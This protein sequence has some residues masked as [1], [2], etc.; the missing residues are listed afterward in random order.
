MVPYYRNY[1]I[2]P[3]GERLVMVC[4][5]DRPDDGEAAR[6]EIVI[7]QNWFEDLRR[8]VPTN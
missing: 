8:L 6:S 3:A 7:V 5:S 1:D 4:P 2:T